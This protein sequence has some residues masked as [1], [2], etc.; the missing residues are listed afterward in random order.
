M[1]ELHNRDGLS[2]VALS[3][4]G[5]EEGIGKSLA[6]GFAVHLSKPIQIEELQTAIPN[7]WSTCR[8][9]RDERESNKKLIFPSLLGLTG[10]VLR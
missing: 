6:A 10:W 1:R 5:M 2:G 9:I 3:G 7:W 8:P 4:Y